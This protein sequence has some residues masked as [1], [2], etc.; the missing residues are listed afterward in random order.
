MVLRPGERRRVEELPEAGSRP[1]GGLQLEVHRQGGEPRGLPERLAVVLQPGER[2][3][4]EELPE[5]GSRPGGGLQL[6]VHRQ[7]GE[8]LERL[9]PRVEV[10]QP[11]V[12]PPD[13]ELLER[14]GPRA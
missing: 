14:L 8:L 5:A 7:G 11:V 2:R 4:V 12:R 9:G 10:H 6:E 3:R 1:G 13:E